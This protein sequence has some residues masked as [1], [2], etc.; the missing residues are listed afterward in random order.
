MITFQDSSDSVTVLRYFEADE[1][2]VEQ[3]VFEDGTVWDVATV[4]AQI[5]A[6]TEAD[7]RLQAFSEGSEIHASG[8]NDVLEGERGNDALYGDEG[9]DELY[10][11]WGDDTLSGGAGLDVLDG[12]DGNDTYIFNAGG[13][14]DVIFNNTRYS[15]DVGLDTLRFGDTIRPDQITLS[16]QKDHLIIAVG[17]GHG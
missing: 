6:G 7:Q 1:H 10:G 2:K 17:D 5:L 8:G 13:G 3:L 16:R 9:D 14:K 4:K 15:S 11:S 12:G